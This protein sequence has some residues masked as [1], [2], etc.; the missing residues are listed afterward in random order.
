[1]KKLLTFTAIAIAIVGFVACEASNMSPEVL[2]KKL[3]GEWNFEGATTMG[4]KTIKSI[5]TRTI[6]LTGPTTANYVFKSK[7][8]G[9]EKE[10]VETGKMWWEVEKKKLAY[11]AGKSVRYL[12]IMPKGY[13][14]TFE[15]EGG[16]H[17][18]DGMPDWNIEE[19]VICEEN[20]TFIDKD[21]TRKIWIGRNIQGVVLIKWAGIFKR[22]I[23]RGASE[24]QDG[25]F[26]FCDA[27]ITFS[28]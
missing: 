9:F 28:Q 1:M 15:I 27:N 20:E 7:I 8:I 16:L 22:T 18:I 23:N 11:T 19:K 6:T 24:R 2:L 12:E 13:S 25:W 17:E 26:H 14:R 5:G 10:M 21:T 4:E 3:S